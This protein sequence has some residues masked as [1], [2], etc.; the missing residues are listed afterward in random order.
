[1][2][3]TS[4]LRWADDAAALQSQS[5]PAVHLPERFRASCAFGGCP[6]MAALSRGSERLSAHH[7]E[8]R[9][10]VTS[11]INTANMASRQP[12]TQAGT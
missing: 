8:T 12:A 3:F 6:Q 5:R 4:P 7:T 10:P 9:G 2:R 11:P 1:M